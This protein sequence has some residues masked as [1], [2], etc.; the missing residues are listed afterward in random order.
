[1]S[2]PRAFLLGIM[3]LTS[4][5]IAEADLILTLN[6]VD[7]SD[8]PLIIWDVQEL[9][10]AVEGSTA[11]GPND[12]SLAAVGGVL[13]A[14]GDPNNHYS[15]AFDANSSEATISLIAE[16]DM[17]I[18]GNSVSP[19]TTVYELCLF[20]NCEQNILGGGGIGLDELIWSEP[21]EG[22]AALEGGPAKDD[23]AQSL[24]K[25]PGAALQTA[26]AGRSS[27]PPA[28]RTIEINGFPDP[29]SYPD[30]NGDEIV[31][32]IDF[33]RFA[34]NWHESGGG[35]DG[36]FDDSGTVDANDLASFAYFWLNGPHPLDVFESFKTALLTDDV[37][38]ATSFFAE[39]SA[40]GYHLLL[41]E[42]RPHFIQM[43]NEM[44][45]M[46][47]MS[48]DTDM[49]LYDLLREEDG[50][51]YGYPVSFVRDEMGQ[52]RMYDF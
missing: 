14:L 6:G 8:S 37:N 24:S 41:G 27:A 31:N 2:K 35:L 17:V 36:D 39:V 9:L 13:E 22:L 21:E 40:E 43:V 34:D 32:F 38:E 30:F 5:S 3:V 16:V 48:F 25:E 44:G 11:T 29:N 19:G 4:V 49:V 15:F 46:V 52:W 12:V 7:T 45:E 42:L 23:A 26:E 47:F 20:Y 50:R 10:I 51:M 33:A 1:M 28:E 18:D